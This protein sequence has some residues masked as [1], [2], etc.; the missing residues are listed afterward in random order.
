MTK[1]SNS[2]LLAFSTSAK[3][4]LDATA[5]ALYEQYKKIMTLANSENLRGGGAD[6]YKS[7]L[8]SVTGNALTGMLQLTSDISDN[9]EKLREAFLALEGDSD[10]ELYD[11]TLKGSA[12]GV[13]SM[14]DTFR[15]QAEAAQSTINQA[16]E[17]IG[18]RTIS[19]QSVLSCFE[20]DASYIDNTESDLSRIDADAKNY[21]QDVREHMTKLLAL[22]AG[23]TGAFSEVTFTSS[24]SFDSASLA[25]FDWY[26]AEDG[27]A[28]IKHLTSDPFIYASGAVSVS[29]GQWAIG[30]L[31]DVF[32]YAGYKYKYADGSYSL[33]DGK[34]SAKGEIGCIDAE[35]YAQLTEF[36][37]GS[38]AFKYAT[39]EGSITAGYTD[40][41][42]GFN[43]NG[44]ATL[45]EVEG[46]LVLGSDEFNGHLSADASVWSADGKVAANISDDGF[47]FG[48]KG[49]AS[50]AEASAE[51]K[52]NFFEYET[53]DEKG[54]TKKKAL[55][56]VGVHG[57]VDLGAS[58]SFWVESEKVGKLGIGDAQVNTLSVDI[59]ASLGLGGGISFTV[60]YVWPLW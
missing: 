52:L 41:Y 57:D 19:T 48:A 17:Y 16:A 23:F 29:E 45:A 21:F 9:V 40:E 51:A 39:A 30:L 59:S 11:A 38:A 3:N 60:P 58:G 43:I 32:A 6:A 7:Y 5:E 12:S 26:Y 10:G 22:V 49:G 50:A 13:R 20:A 24:N 37:N 34:Y 46:E 33:V 54:K 42:K 18:A 8:T 44:E 47:Q 55:L 27:S 1:L 56:G 35:A 53:Q 14:R 31:Q 15:S 36:L 4:N 28:L 2:D 25:D